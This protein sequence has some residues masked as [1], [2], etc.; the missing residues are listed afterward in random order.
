MKESSMKKHGSQK[1]EILMEPGKVSRESRIGVSEGYNSIE[2]KG[3]FQ[4]GALSELP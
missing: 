1:R 3:I 4:I 2:I